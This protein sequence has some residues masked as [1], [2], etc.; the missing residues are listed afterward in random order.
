VAKEWFDTRHD[1]HRQG[2]AVRKDSD[3]GLIAFVRIQDAGAHER[4]LSITGD[5]VKIHR[6]T[7]V[8]DFSIRREE[9]ATGTSFRSGVAGL[10]E[11][12]APMAS[13]RCQTAG[14]Q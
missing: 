3:S 8:I 14:R 13:S 11:A 2:A 1:G 6:I 9:R 12:S 5:L 10:Q 7:C 4:E